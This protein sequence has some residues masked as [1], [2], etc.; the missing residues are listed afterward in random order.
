MSLLFFLCFMMQGMLNF[1]TFICIHVTVF[2]ILHFNNEHYWDF[3]KSSSWEMQP[4][5]SF[6]FY[7]WSVLWGGVSLSTNIPAN[8][9]FSWPTVVL[10]LFFTLFSSEIFW[11][12]H[13]RLCEKSLL[14][15]VLECLQN[16]LLAYPSP[17]G[18]TGRLCFCIYTNSH[19]K[20]HL[21]LIVINMSVL[22]LWAVRL[23]C[24]CNLAQGTFSPNGTVCQLTSPWWGNPSLSVQ[25][26]NWGRPQT[27]QL[28]WPSTHQIHTHTQARRSI[29]LL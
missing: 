14:S 23:F 16:T 10:F 19:V 26:Q 29:E 27:G 17:L 25:L 20:R 2:D 7:H 5:A 9:L 3:I 13:K 18:H 12:W 4:G 11:G 22:C 1:L 6:S 15:Q 24:V 28:C 21:K 8:F